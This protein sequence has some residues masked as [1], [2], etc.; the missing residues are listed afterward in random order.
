MNG[1]PSLDKSGWCRCCFWWRRYGVGGSGGGVSWCW[2]LNFDEPVQCQNLHFVSSKKVIRGWH[3][4]RGGII[5][6]KEVFRSSPS[7]PSV[8]HKVL[9]LC[10]TCIHSFLSP[11]SLLP[12]GVHIGKHRYIKN[13]L[14]MYSCVCLS[15]VYENW[16]L[17]CCCLWDIWIQRESIWIGQEQI[18]ERTRNNYLLNMTV[19]I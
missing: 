16:F 19:T 5:V 15:S 8:L 18:W 1:L 14:W 13:I 12:L 11:H 6:G 2:A 17:D 10:P 3:K 9:L 7:L 4:K